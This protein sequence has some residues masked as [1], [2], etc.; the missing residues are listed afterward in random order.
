MSVINSVNGGYVSMLPEAFAREP[1]Q[2]WMVLLDGLNE[3]TN[4]HENPVESTF[5]FSPS[6]N[7]CWVLQ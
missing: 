2:D 1:W 7:S 3:K 4:L 6:S 5:S